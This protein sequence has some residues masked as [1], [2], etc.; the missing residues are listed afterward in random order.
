M[1]S[2]WVS[3]FK[4]GQADFYGWDGSFRRTVDAPGNLLASVDGRYFVNFTKGQLLDSTGTLVRP[5]AEPGLAQ[6]STSLNWAADGDYFCGLEKIGG[7]YALV[8]ED[9]AGRGVRLDLDVPSDLVPPEG[10]RFMSVECSLSADRAIVHSGSDAGNRA[11]LMSL[12][13]GN[14]IT[15][16]EFR[17][18]YY[19]SGS[20]PDLHW[21]LATKSNGG[22]TTTEVLDATKGTVQVVLDGYFWLFTPD[23]KNVVGTDRHQVATVVDWRTKGELWRG[24]STLDTVLAQSDPST[25][26]MLLLLSTGSAMAGT[27]TYDYWIVGGAGS[28]FRFNPRGCLSY[29]VS[30]TR[31]CGF[32]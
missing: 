24:P 4:H 13:D 20:S 19:G 11:A 3:P 8:A 21:L 26:T 7:G 27:A 6:N 10:L 17:S 25:N 1:L 15:D 28:G 22:K 30:P 32:T 23:S 31:V 12:P 9:V 29:V 2:K 18:G 5:F 14:L 16:I